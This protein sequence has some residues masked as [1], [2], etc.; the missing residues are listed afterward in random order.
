MPGTRYVNVRTNNIVEICN[1]GPASFTIV[2]VTDDGYGPRRHAPSTSFHQNYLA[3]NG[4]PHSSGYVPVRTLPGNHPAAMNTEIDRM[5]LLEHL[6]D[7]SNAELAALIREQQKVEEEAKA[8]IKR[9]KAIAKGRR[10][11][12][13]LE[14]Y[15]DTALVFS[16]GKKFDAKTA[17]KVLDRTRL[18]Q[19]SILK[20]DATLAKKI[21]GDDTEEYK[22][23]LKDH[24]FTLTV[25]EATDE[26]RLAALA[27]TPADVDDEIFELN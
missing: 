4:Q 10:K 15:G 16:S 1:E 25:R 19:I 8:L 11:E 12:V 23:C 14:L 3:E 9:A 21:L 7:L 13:G 18:H 2:T 6:D 27:E 24:G 17:I 20:P 26:D 22:S 5:E